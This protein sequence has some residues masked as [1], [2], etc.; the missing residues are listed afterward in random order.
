LKKNSISKLDQLQIR[1]RLEDREEACLS[2]FAA[3][4]RSSRGRCRAEEPSPVRLAFQRDRD[5]IIHSKAF[6]RLKHK[7]QVFIAPVDDHYVTRLTHTLE[8]SQIARTISRALSLNEDLTEAISLG[9]DLGHTPFGHVGEDVLNQLYP[10]G[11]RHNE[12]SLRVVDCLENNGLGLNLTWE[13]REGILHHSKTKVRD[14]LGESWGTV[15]TLEGQVCKIA[16]V[17]A[18]INHDIGDAIRAG[19]IVESDLPPTA[20]DVLGRSHSERINTMVCDIVQR[21]WPSGEEDGI[22]PPRISMSPRIRKATN[23]LHEFLYE[24]VYNVSSAQPDAEKAREVVRFLYG[25]FNRNKDC[26]PPE[27]SAGSNDPER[28]VVDLIAGMTDP[29]AA[30]TAEGLGWPSDG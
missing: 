21:S 3:K 14:I 15:N 28:R 17:V 29:Y 20:A 1:Q 25:Y 10:G 19:V 4:S 13:V 8:V 30:R 16:D 24:R 26:L 2:L 11:F 9:H 12:Q 22:V 6:R 7:T 27:Y 5:R 23:E 18:Y